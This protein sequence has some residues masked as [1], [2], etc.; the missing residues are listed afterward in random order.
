MQTTIPKRLTATLAR[1]A[2]AKAAQNS[3]A[4]MT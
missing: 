4:D 2:L 3:I 1:C